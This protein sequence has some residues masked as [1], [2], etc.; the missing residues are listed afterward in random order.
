VTSDK[1]AIEAEPLIGV[2][3]DLFFNEDLLYYQ[4]HICWKDGKVS[5]FYFPG[6]KTDN[7]HVKLSFNRV[8]RAF[9]EAF[10]NRDI[11]GDVE[12]WSVRILDRNKLEKCQ[13]SPSV[14]GGAINMKEE[15]G[16]ENIRCIRS[17]TPL[18]EVEHQVR[19][20]SVREEA[21]ELQRSNRLWKVVLVA[22]LVSTG[23]SV[24]TARRLFNLSDDEGG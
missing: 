22:K 21:L 2:T 24:E 13:G 11:D 4:M 12:A 17:V 9:H 1:K 16:N 7:P 10:P 3:L 8:N 20:S 19:R 23:I 15:E 14:E 18:S 5:D 6:E